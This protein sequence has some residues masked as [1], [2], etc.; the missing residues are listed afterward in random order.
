MHPFLLGSIKSQNLY[1]IYFSYTRLCRRLVRK[2]GC[3]FF[4]IQIPYILMYIDIF[5]RKNAEKYIIPPNRKLWTHTVLFPPT[6]R[7]PVA[8]VLSTIY[9]F[10]KFRFLETTEISSFYPKSQIIFV[11]SQFLADITH[12]LLH[13]VNIR[14]I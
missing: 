14:W 13:D 12:M 3:G 1:L 7:T 10:L 6:H 5:F 11:L 4:S 2:Y 8:Q 9:L